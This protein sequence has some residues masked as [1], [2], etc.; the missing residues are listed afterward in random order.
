MYCSASCDQTLMTLQDIAQGWIINLVS[1]VN[2][3]ALPV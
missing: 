1:A 3:K 2:G